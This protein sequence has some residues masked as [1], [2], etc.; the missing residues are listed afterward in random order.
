MDIS[1]EFAEGLKE[2]AI[3]RATLLDLV[4]DVADYLV[5]YGGGQG[6]TLLAR[7]RAILE[8]K[9]TGGSQ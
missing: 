8:P 3:E 9:E 5:V 7:A 2:W 6:G 1:K 4:K